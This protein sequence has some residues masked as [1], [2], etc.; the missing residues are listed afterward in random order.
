[1]S[2]GTAKVSSGTALG[3]N[4]SRS[5]P[6]S[7]NVGLD[8]CQRGPFWRSFWEPFLIKSR[9][10]SASF[11]T[12]NF[13]RHFERI[14]MDFGAHFHDFWGP[15]SILNPKGRKYEKPMFYLR[16]TYVFEGPGLSFLVQKSIKNDVGTRCGIGTYFFMIWGRFWH[17][18]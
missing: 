17:P 1:M 6:K 14:L 7:D 16:K 18:F 12:S 15:K 10:F 4:R 3:T 5:G 8:G 13:G 11:F 2:S 9:S